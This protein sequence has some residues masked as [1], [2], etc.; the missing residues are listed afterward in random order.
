MAI[1]P[2]QRRLV[3]GGIR[4]LLHITDELS[5]DDIHIV[6][7]RAPCRIPYQRDKAVVVHGAK[8]FHR[9]GDRKIA[10]ADQTVVDAAVGILHSVVQMD[11]TNICAEI[12]DDLSGA[13]TN[14]EV[15]GG[16]IPQRRDVIGRKVFKRIAQE[17]GIGIQTAGLDQQRDLLLFRISPHGLDQAPG[18]RDSLFHIRMRFGAQADIRDVQIGGDTHTALYLRD[19][20][21]ELILVRD[22]IDHVDAGQRQTAVIEH[23]HRRRRRIIL[24]YAALFGERCVIDIVRLDTLEFEV[25]SGCTKFFKRNIMPAFGRK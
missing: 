3:L 10:L 7:L 22:I 9:L 15:S 17:R 12:T 1:V 25:F 5:E 4:E 14:G 19:R 2:I 21:I 20:G 6:Q 16:H 18:I 13:F 24:K 8:G 11:M 23:P